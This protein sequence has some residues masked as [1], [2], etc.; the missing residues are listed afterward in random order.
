MDALRR[1]PAAR[2]SVDAAVGVFE[3]LGN[4]FAVAS[5]A[6]GV[7]RDLTAKADFLAEHWRAAGA[8]GGAGLAL[9][10]PLSTQGQTAGDP[11][12]SGGGGGGGEGFLSSVPQMDDDSSAGMQNSLA[13]FL[14]LTIRVDSFNTFD[15]AWAGSNMLDNWNFAA[16]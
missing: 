5:S 8:A 9:S 10:P 14:G 2:K 16:E 7:T 4:N 11:G 1:A 12:G 3:V 15:S 6:A 13:D